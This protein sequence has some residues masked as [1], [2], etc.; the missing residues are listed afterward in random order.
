MQPITDLI[1]LMD[2]PGDELARV[3]DF[4]SD[5]TDSVIPQIIVNP[6]SGSH[7]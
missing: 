4:F 7:S 5:I 1:N 3:V 2:I 6:G